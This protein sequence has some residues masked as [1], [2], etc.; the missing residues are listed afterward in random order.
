V[1]LS[2]VKNDQ[3]SVLFAV[4]VLVG[5]A[6]FGHFTDAGQVIVLL[7]VASFVKISVKDA[8]PEVTPVVNVKVQSP[9]SVAVKTFPFARLIVAAVE[10]F[11]NALNFSV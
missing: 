6:L 10:V 4:V 3:T 7:G 1:P 8:V 9:V 5:T 11:P 2:V